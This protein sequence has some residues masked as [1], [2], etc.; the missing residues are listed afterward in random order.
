MGA[1]TDPPAG[2][3]KRRFT[4]QRPVA[5]AD[6]AGG[7]TIG[8]ETVAALWGRLEWLAG[9]EQVEAARP[10]QSVRYRVLTR[11]RAG[12]DA[13]QRLVLGTRIFDVR[14]VADPDGDRR[15]LLWL[16][17]EVMP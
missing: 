10:Q 17:E 14:A 1:R 6:G 7:E 4:L 12:T 16:V 2:A 3:L 5:T 15:R 8:W 9:E 11:W 13:G